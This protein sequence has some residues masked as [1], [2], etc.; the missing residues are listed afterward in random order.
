MIAIQV[1]VFLTVFFTALAIVMNREVRGWSNDEID[2]ELIFTVPSTAATTQKNFIG[3]QLFS[4]VSRQITNRI[5][6]EQA[7]RLREHD[8]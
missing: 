3:G 4:W 5:S 1:T 6:L 7:R 8:N 2:C